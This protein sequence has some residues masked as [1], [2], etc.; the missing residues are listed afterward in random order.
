MT[1][2]EFNALP[3]EQKKQHIAPGDIVVTDSGARLL[4][5]GTKSPEG[6]FGCYITKRV[7]DW[8]FEREI[9]DI[10]RPVPPAQPDAVPEI[11]PER[12][13][14]LRQ[15]ILDFENA[16][17]VDYDESLSYLAFLFRKYIEQ[18]HGIA[19]HFEREAK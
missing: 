4:F 11:V 6:N 13:T 18:Q 12:I 3:L 5:C 17:P 19:D 1:P 2:Q 8:I 16:Q 9:T 7:F 10:I 14:A 15:K